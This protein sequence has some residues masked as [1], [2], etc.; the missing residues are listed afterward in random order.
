MGKCLFIV[1]T[2][3]WTSLC[4]L[5][6][7]VVTLVNEQVFNLIVFLSSLSRKFLGGWIHLCFILRL[8]RGLLW[9]ALCPQKVARFGG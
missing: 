9:R 2:R 4:E 3:F 6:L 5:S 7:L 8:R 1:A